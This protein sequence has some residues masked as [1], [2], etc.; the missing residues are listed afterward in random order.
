[1]RNI[2]RT[3]HEQRRRSSAALFG[4]H[5]PGGSQLPPG[6]LAGMERRSSSTASLETLLLSERRGSGPLN[7]DSCRLSALPGHV[8]DKRRLSLAGNVGYSSLNNSPQ[9][10]PRRRLVG[11]RTVVP[12]VITN[13]GAPG[14]TSG[15][16]FQ[17]ATSSRKRSHLKGHGSSVHEEEDEGI[18]MKLVILTMFIICSGCL[19]VAF[20]AY[21]F[22]EYRKSPEASIP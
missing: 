11:D 9:S 4:E 6:G 2:I 19:L 16:T 17:S 3:S 21:I 7:V 12:S 20:M 18:N 15:S 8:V 14:M 22:K 1:M 10:S 13:H 5:S